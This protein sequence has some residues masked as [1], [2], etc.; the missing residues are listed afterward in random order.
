MFLLPDSGRFLVSF[1]A[2]EIFSVTDVGSDIEPDPIEP[3]AV[4][5]AAGVEEIARGGE[6]HGGSH[7]FQVRG[8]FDGG[9][10]LDRARIGEAKGAHVAVGPGL[11]RRP[12]DG[13]VAVVA[14]VAVSVEF[15]VGGVS[16]ADILDNDGIAACNGFFESFVISK[17]RLLVVGRSIDER[18]E[19]PG[20]G[21]E[22]NIGA[23]NYT[24]AHA[25]RN[26]L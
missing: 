12:L 18:W 7:G 17:C 22:Q 2:G 26:I 3:G 13:V 9:E 8:I 21:G 24:V 23:E 10:P 6:R 11:S 20:L 15:T 5:G 14:L 25:N 16:A 1:R 4:K 19:A